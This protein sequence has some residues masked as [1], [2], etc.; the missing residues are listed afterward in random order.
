[1]RVVAVYSNVAMWIHL[2][3]GLVFGCLYL[4]C[5]HQHFTPCAKSCKCFSEIVWLAESVLLQKELRG[6]GSHWQRWENTRFIFN[7]TQ[8]CLC[9]STEIHVSGIEQKKGTMKAFLVLES[10]TGYWNFTLNLP[11][12][13]KCG[14]EP[15]SIINSETHTV[16]PLSFQTHGAGSIKRLHSFSGRKVVH[17]GFFFFFF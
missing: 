10:T 14:K 1:M 6:D 8:R 11:S 3:W 12:C 7:E 2:T 5:S 15:G 4:Y 17:V 13:F 9:S 16:Q